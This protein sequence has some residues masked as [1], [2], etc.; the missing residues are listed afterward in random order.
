[1]VNKSTG[2][3]VLVAALAMSAG[4]AV[5]TGLP[6]LA[7][8][9]DV[10]STAL[11]GI[12]W[13]ATSGVQAA[14]TATGM[15]SFV[16]GEQ[17]VLLDND[18]PGGAGLKAGHSGTVLCTDADDGTGDILV[19][20]DLWTDGKTGAI[21]CLNGLNALYPANSAIWINS[22][23]V[24]IGHH[25]K[26]CG[27]IRKG[28]EGCVNFETDDG[29]AY[30]V[31]ASA[32]LYAALNADT[33]IL[34]FDDRVQIEGLLNTTPPAPGVARLCP[35]FEGDLFHPIV[36]P[37]PGSP[38]LPGP[39]TINLA[40]NPLQLLPDPN[41][42]GP[43]YTYDGCTSITLELNFRAQL[44]V[45]VTPASGVNGTWSGTVVP[46]VV[47]PGTVTVQICVRVEHLDI[48]T[49]PAGN[50]QVATITLSAVPAM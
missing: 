50:M 31:V 5:L 22:H 40:G 38:G 39:F 7:A 43:G 41:S 11:A 15:F 49:L 4:G 28:L 9:G 42:I 1:M 25:F 45:Q 35:Q 29:H 32:T 37:C 20:W 44:S 3:M 26:Q 27:T 8:Q 34:R 33:G 17:V 16:P 14:D 12:H 36:S 6:G 19:S 24:R 30:N 10:V 18:P 21:A 46:N 48:S 23:L 2:V 47:G 13:V